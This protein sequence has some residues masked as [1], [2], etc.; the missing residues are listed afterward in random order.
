VGVT[1][2]KVLLFVAGCTAAAA[3]AY[4]SDVFDL[5][6]AGPP[7]AVVSS[8]EPPA[9]TADP[10]TASSSG[11]KF[12]AATPPASASA[13]AQ[14]ILPPSFDVVRVEGDGS[15]VIA[16]KAAPNAKVEI[17][18]GPHVIGNTIAGPDGDFAI[19]IE[20]PLKPGAY[21]LVLRS[22]TLDNVVTTS[23]ETA[24]VSIPETESGQ[25]VVLIEQP[26]ELSKPVTVPETASSNPAAALAEQLKAAVAAPVELL[27]AVPISESKIVVEAL[28][29]E[30]RNIFL[31]G[32]ADPGR[33]VRAYVNDILLGQTE[34]SPD[35]RFLIEAE[36]DLPVGDQIIHVD[37]L[38]PD[39]V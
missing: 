20:E 37:E 14:E 22:T 13:A 1:P 23:P 32:V 25:V 35:G 16:G 2:F 29:I 26:G 21:Q 11:E 31:A 6:L 17:V 30:G 36:R 4:V 33:K 39:G 28:E 18:T 15:I 8:P 38:E 10:K 19:V 12:A 27:P 3:M 7:T 9:P 5:Y 24:A 34:A